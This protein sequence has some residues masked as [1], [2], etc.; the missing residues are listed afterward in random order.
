MQ[1]HIKFFNEIVK[2]NIPTASAELYKEIHTS[3]LVPTNYTIPI[4]V[5]EEEIYQYKSYLRQWGPEYT[6]FPRYGLPLVNLSGTIDDEF[7]PSCAPLDTWWDHYGDVYWDLDFN[8]PTEILDLSCFDGL[9][10]IKKYMI[11]SNVLWWDN[12]G[13]FKPHV[14]STPEYFTHLRLWGTNKESYLL[15]CNGETV[16]FEPGRLYIIDTSIVHEAAAK[17]D[18]TCTFFLSFK[19]DVLHDKRITI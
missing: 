11:R 1:K 16:D 17:E 5:F 19:L 6:E 7:D 9:N 14:D 12:T 10:N 4:D 18:F 3:F 13:H 2:R 8:K 15:K